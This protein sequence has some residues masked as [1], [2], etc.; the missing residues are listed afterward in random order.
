MLRLTNP[1]TDKVIILGAMISCTPT[2]YKFTAKMEG[3]DLTVSGP[4]PEEKIRTMRQLRNMKCPIPWITTRCKL[5][6]DVVLVKE[7]LEPLTETDPP[8]LVFY[9][10]LEQLSFVHQIGTH[11]RIQRK[12]IRRTTI[13]E[14]K[15]LLTGLSKM[16]SDISVEK[17]RTDIISTIDAIPRQYLTAV[18]AYFSTLPADELKPD[19]YVHLFRSQVGY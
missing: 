19:N 1:N 16:E 9:S 7:K 18:R 6:D 12:Y 10:I 8:I 11:G 17:R 2:T 5:H 14:T 4:C 13:G 3:F 15:Y